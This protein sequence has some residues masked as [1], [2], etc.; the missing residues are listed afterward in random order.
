MLNIIL[1]LLDRSPYSVASL[2][3][4]DKTSGMGRVRTQNTYI[5]TANT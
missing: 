5:P 1:F 4:W 3:Q 2:N